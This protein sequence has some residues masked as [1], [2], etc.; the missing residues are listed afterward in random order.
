[1]AMPSQRLLV[2]MTD[3]KNNHNQTQ[4]EQTIVRPTPATWGLNLLKILKLKKLL[5]LGNR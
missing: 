3:S 2:I 1:M 4:F 5:K